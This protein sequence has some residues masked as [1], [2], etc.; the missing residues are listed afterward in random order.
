MVAYLQCGSHQWFSSMWLAQC[1]HWDTEF[2]I[3]TFFFITLLYSP[4]NP[5]FS[6]WNNKMW[7]KWCSETFQAGLKEALHLLPGSLATIWE[8]EAIMSEVQ[9]PSNCHSGKVNS[10]HFDDCFSWAQPFRHLSQGTRH[11]NSILLLL[12]QLK[13]QLSR[14]KWP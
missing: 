13:C 9:L 1:P 10:G 2:V 7:P 8:H 14:S 3:H 4:L 12:A 5:C 11:G 6:K